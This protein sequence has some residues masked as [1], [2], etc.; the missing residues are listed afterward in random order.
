MSLIIL[1][2]SEHYKEK[3]EGKDGNKGNERLIKK[4]SLDCI[5]SNQSSSTQRLRKSVGDEMKRNEDGWGSECKRSVYSKEER[6]RDHHQES[7]TNTEGENI[8]FLSTKYRENSFSL[9]T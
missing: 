6:T 4:C 2:W 1:L 7:M 9:R 8:H 5:T 3:D